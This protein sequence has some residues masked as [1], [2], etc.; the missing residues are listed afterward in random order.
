MNR[1]FLVLLSLTFTFQALA[2][3]DLSENLFSNTN[4]KVQYKIKEY[5]TLNDCLEHICTG[6]KVHPV[7]FLHSQGAIVLAINKKHK[8][9]MLKSNKSGN[10]I[11]Y[12]KEDISIGRGCLLGVCVKDIVV[13]DSY[14]HRGQAKV[15]AINSHT[16]KIT[17]VSDESGVL[18]HYNVYELSVLKYQGDH[19][20]TIRYGAKF[21]TKRKKIN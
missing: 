4:N 14:R 10:I 17:I 12:K 15:L 19:S 16:N 7:N 6:E 11:F 1:I 3:S 18:Y 9:L 2:I 8:T 5:F 13:R 21:K 20:N